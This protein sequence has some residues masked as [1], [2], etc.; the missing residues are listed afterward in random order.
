[1]G[2]FSC[3]FSRPLLMTSRYASICESYLTL[4]LETRA[5]PSLRALSSSSRPSLVMATVGIIG[6]SMIFERASTS[7]SPRFR[8]TSIMF[9]ATRTGKPS[10]I[11]WNMST[12]EGSRRVASATTRTQSGLAVCS[13]LA[14]TCWSSVSAVSE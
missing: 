6:T 8:A 10:S 13:I 5:L 12:R 3:A 2:Y 14:A 11:S 1:M 9:M 4:K 7:S